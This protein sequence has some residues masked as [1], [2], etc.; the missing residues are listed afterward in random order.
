[1]KTVIVENGDEVKK[2]HDLV[3]L[4]KDSKLELSEN[5]QEHID[6]LNP[7]YQLPRYPD[8]SCKGPILKYNKVIAQENLIKLNRCFYG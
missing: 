7:H 4:L 3:M 5:F 1:M 6:N 2:V 8:I